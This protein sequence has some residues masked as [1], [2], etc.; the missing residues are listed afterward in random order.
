MEPRGRLP[1]TDDAGVAPFPSVSIESNASNWRAHAG[2]QRPPASLLTDADGCAAGDGSSRRRAQAC[3]GEAAGPAAT[4]RPSPQAL[5]AVLQVM[6]P[7]ACAIRQIE[8]ESQGQLHPA[9]LLTG[10]SC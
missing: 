8:E 9:G 1:L 10:V 4:G 6:M 5:M 2:C 3:R 7:A